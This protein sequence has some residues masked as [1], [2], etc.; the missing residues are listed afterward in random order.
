MRRV[1][2]AI[3]LGVALKTLGGTFEEPAGA[4]GSPSARAI[5]NAPFQMSPP[6]SMAELKKL[7]LA[8]V[9]AFEL[10]DYVYGNYAGDFPCPP[11]ADL[12]P[13]RAILV[14][15]KQ[16][17]YRLVFSKEASYCPWLEFASGAA[18]SFQ[19]FEGNGGWAELFNQ[20]G[21]QERNSFVD[22]LESGPNRVWIRWI[23]F[24]VNLV[25]G[26]P[27]YRGIE[28]FWAYP[29]GLILHRQSFTTLLP[30]KHHG[31]AREPIELIGL[32]PV[33]KKWSDVLRPTDRPGERHALAALDPFSEK[34][35]DVYWTLKRNA[36]W[37]STHRREGCSWRELDD[38]AG[39]V[40]V[41]PLREGSPFVSFG[42][43]S[44]FSHDSTRIKEHTFGD[45]GGLG[46]GSSS[47][48]HWPIGWVNSQGHVMDA[49]SAKRYPNHF[50]PA[51]MDFFALPNE[52]VERRNYFSLIGVGGKDMEPIRR[53][54]RGW[55]ESGARGTA[56][57]EMIKRLR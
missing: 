51:G 39:I 8:G 33:G 35:Y 52:Q 11:H 44:G 30:G 45:T 54:A 4:A 26:Q 6:L 12:N 23:Y 40:L 10:T 22:V 55:L 46:W 42:D 32:C 27:A 17:P 24:G 13:K 1:L 48:D 34:R 19:F 50:S 49:Q 43:A 20:W 16:L 15:W 21:R 37:E 36:L 47:W 41:L 56:D 7:Q 53:L 29:N 9:S 14:C 38:A 25:K 57:P 2:I 3:V 28:D 18:C 31:Y 5:Y